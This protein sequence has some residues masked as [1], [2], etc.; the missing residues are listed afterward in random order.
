MQST[1]EILAKKIDELEKR[2]TRGYLIVY[3][4]P[5]AK[6]ET[7][8]PLEQKCERRHHKRHARLKPCSDRENSLPLRA[9]RCRRSRG[10]CFQIAGSD[11]CLG[12][13][14]GE[15]CLKQQL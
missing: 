10:H 7:S 11:R 3:D 12:E 15:F 9:T 2:S 4:I 14:G 5:E 6:Y 1:I 8:E 13:E